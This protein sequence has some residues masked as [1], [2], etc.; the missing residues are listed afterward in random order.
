MPVAELNKEAGQALT[1]LDDIM[2]GEPIALVQ[3]RMEK[4]KASAAK[5]VYETAPGFTGWPVSMHGFVGNNHN[6]GQWMDAYERKLPPHLDDAD[7]TQPVDTFLRKL[8][9]NYAHEGV[10]AGKPNGKFFVTRKQVKEVAA[11]VVETHLHKKGADNKAFLKKHYKKAWDHFD[12][13]HEG[14]MDVTW[15]STLLKYM[16]RPV[17]DINLE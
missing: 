8:I 5:K 12:V 16:C 6:N 2:N 11:E 17:A 1:Q 10:T 15:V 4:A 9:Q 7:L 13:N 14:T 3:E